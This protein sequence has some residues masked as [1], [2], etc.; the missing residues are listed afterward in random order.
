MGTLVK[1]ASYNEERRIALKAIMWYTNLF[2]TS[3]I[4][5]GFLE[6]LPASKQTK[7]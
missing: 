1:A 7:F 5:L 2:L 3:A 6:S 4:P